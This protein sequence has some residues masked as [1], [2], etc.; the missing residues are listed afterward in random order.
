MQGA[1]MLIRYVIPFGPYAVGDVRDAGHDEAQQLLAHGV[2]EIDGAP[3]VRK[4]VA[5]APQGKRN[6]AI[7]HDGG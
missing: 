7:K 6:A 4:A 5:P 3:V 2:V 1:P